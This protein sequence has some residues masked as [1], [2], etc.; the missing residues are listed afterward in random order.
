MLFV[1]NYTIREYYMREVQS[2]ARGLRILDI[3]AEHNRPQSVTH[4]AGILEIDKSTVSRLLKT[5]ENYGFVQQERHSRHYILGKH[6]YAMGWQLVNRYPLRETAQ[7]YIQRLA[8]QT[9]ESSHIAIY[10]SGNVI[11]IDDIQPETSLLRVVGQTGRQLYLHNTALGKALLAFGDFP[12]PERMPK[13]TDATITNIDEFQKHLEEIC[14]LGYALDNEE[15]EVGV[16]C[17]AVPVF[18]DIGFV[19]ASIG[20]S[21]P[22]IRLPDNQIS[23]L[24]DMVIATAFELSQE[25]GFNAGN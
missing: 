1:G 16:R 23:G 7:P 6:F 5:M 12:L 2:L 25:L 24:A 14:Y 17:I 19:I 21:G 18:N 20:I 13:L 3:M 10:S 11:V 9:G 22:A 4:L 8:H 15:N